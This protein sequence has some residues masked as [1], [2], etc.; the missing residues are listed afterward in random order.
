MSTPVA[1]PIRFAIAP[2]SPEFV[3][4]V[5]ATLRDD[6]GR[7]V[8]VSVAEGG[9]PLRDQLRRA[10]PGERIILG[11]YQAVALPSEFAAIGPVFVSADGADAPPPIRDALPAGY[12]NR[13]F[14]LR[15]YDA[16][17]R[18]AHST[19]VEPERAPDEFAAMLARPGVAY[20]HAHF[21]GHG[22]FA[23]RID[24]SESDQAA[25]SG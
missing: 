9:E 4:R 7:T 6:F 21:A 15:G 12:F 1:S 16:L 19:L 5:R 24:R 8:R 22:C 3:Q 10:A 25:R 18:I 17:D 11:G 20:L 13:T 14:A 2:I 23:A